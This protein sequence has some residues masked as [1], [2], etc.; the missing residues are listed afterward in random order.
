MSFETGLSGLN[1]ASKDLDV[2]GN[3]VANANVVGFK[4]AQAQFADV[5][6][7][8]LAGGGANEIGIGT[9]VANVAQQFTQGNITVTN[10]PLDVAING[11][12]FFRMETQAG[13]VSYTRN[14]QFHFDSQGFIINAQGL[15]LTG[16]GVDANGNIVQSSPAPIQTSFADVPPKTT[17]QFRVGMNF[18]SRQGP[19]SNPPSG[20]NPF[21]PTDPTMYNF[22]TSGNVFDT[23]G[24]SHVLSMYFVNTG[25]GA[26]DVYS[27]VDGSLPNANLGAGAGTPVPFTFNN[28]GQLTAGMPL[29]A[30]LAVATGAVTPLPFTLD[31]T[32]STQFG[33][34]FSVN[35]MTQDGYASGSLA[36]FSVADDGTIKGQYTNGQSRN[37]AQ[38]VL[39]NFINP[40]GMNPVGDNQFEDTANSG[41]PV[42]GTAGTGTF[43]V[44]Q[45]AAVEDSNVDLT[46]QLVNMITA[47]RNYQA[48]AQT[49]KTEDAIMQTLVNLR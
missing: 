17:T 5:F 9:K 36:G 10:N 46:Q 3:N 31:F 24:N 6:A 41:L 22:S 14:G 40:Q 2:I 30:S 23:L 44:L 35:S 1:S 12:G 43:G 19:P 49:I 34:P 13:A 4:S 18:D 32:G 37:L 29:S 38:V 28:L 27:A 26:W 48:N 25:P 39:T 42:M 8:S 20:A 33:S 16:Y 11:R 7:S 47:Q 21:D 15:R 45:S